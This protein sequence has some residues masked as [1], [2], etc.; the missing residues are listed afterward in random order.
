MISDLFFS[1]LYQPLY[2][3]LVF[4]SVAIPFGGVGLSVVLLTL[5][6]KFLLFPLTHKSTKTQAY[7]KKLEPEIKKVKELYKD[8][9]QQQSRKI[10]ELYNKHGI[11]PF[12]GCMLFIVQ[13]PIIIAL[14]WVFWKGLANGINEEQLYSFVTAPENF[15]MT[16]FGYDIGGKSIILAL[17]AGVT[18][19][20]QMKLAVPPIPKRD[21]TQ[22]KPSLK[23]DFA[24][25]F[26]LQMRY[27]LPVFVVFISYTI[28]A[29]IALYW[30][31]SNL[32]SIG[33]EL[34]VKRKANTLMGSQGEK[35]ENSE[36]GGVDPVKKIKEE[37]R[38]RISNL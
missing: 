19:F 18:Q 29:A 22:G 10:I 6:V 12:S 14:Y 25:S 4:L 34:L 5:G 15:S 23:D 16:F 28:S 35:P 1:I 13:L 24:R 37:E 7:I 30:V 27:G 17:L 36:Q 20:Y 9:K 38:L 32:F 2:N 21:P 8:D 26:N 3:G 33:H 11:N 31:T